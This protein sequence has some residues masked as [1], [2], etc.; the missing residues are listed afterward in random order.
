MAADLGTGE[1][2]DP[3]LGPS[4]RVP[5]SLLGDL[6]ALA[7]PLLQQQERQSREAEGEGEDAEMDGTAEAK[8]AGEPVTA[9]QMASIGGGTLL[10]RCAWTPSGCIYARQTSALGLC[11]S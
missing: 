7:Q 2:A 4:L 1:C 3:S 10:L 6:H 5:G 9:R 11:L 8:T